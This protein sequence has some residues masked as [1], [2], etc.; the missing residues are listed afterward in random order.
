MVQPHGMVQPQVKRIWVLVLVGLFAGAGVAGFLLARGSGSTPKYRVARVERGPLTAVVAANGTLNSVVRVQV[1]T[2]VSGQIQKLLVDFNSVVRKDQVIAQIDPEIFEA[3]VSQARADV[4][5]TQATV[6]TQ[7][8][9]VERARADIENA[10]AAHAEAKAQTAKAQVAVLDTKRDLDR[11]T[12]LF[13]RQLIAKSDLDTSQAAHDSAVAQLDSARAHE[14]ALE[15]AIQSAIAQLR[16]AEAMLVSARA[17]V[18]QK[19]AGLKQAQVDLDHTTIRAPVQGVVVSR[20]VD[21]GQTVAASLQAPVLFTI[22]QDLTKMQVET[23]VDEA[24]IGRI[25]LDDR[26]TFTV[27]AFP[28]ETFEGTV[29]QIRKAGQIVQNVVT[30]T[31]VVAVDNPAGKLLPGMTANVKLV[32]AEK[33]SVLKV[34]NAALRFRP[35]GVDAAGPSGPPGG[36]T[37]RSQPVLEQM[38]DGLV[39]NLTLSGDQQKK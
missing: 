17:Q 3:K 22:A 32:V 33:P 30:Y 27:D 12:E 16:V 15:S 31:V 21:V 4:E 13:A 18:E 25:K 39:R 19:D 34:P 26:A 35:A 6:V 28:G 8:A 29:T 38:R 1:G 7:E 10:R 24:D 23:S 14:Q 36:A 20:Q 11:K 9:Q 37:A 2:Q 5:S